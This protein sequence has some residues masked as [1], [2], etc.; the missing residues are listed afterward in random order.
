MDVLDQLMVEATGSPAGDEIA[1]PQGVI[2]KVN[3]S[4]QAMIDLILANPG[5]SQNALA[6][7]FGY[8]PS[9]ISQVISSDAFQAAMAAR[10]KEVVDPTLLLTVQERFEAI[11]RRSQDILMEKLSKPADIV[12]DQ[13][14]IAALQT[15]ARARGYGA[16]ETPQPQVSPVEVEVHLHAMGDRLVHLL[17][18]KRTETVDLQVEAIAGSLV[19]G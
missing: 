5:I 18:R 19:E 10:A 17:Q 8:S 15:A 16:R 3:Y 4:H 1:R 2:K 13:L 12:P 7:A 6:A 11:V 9:W 14:A